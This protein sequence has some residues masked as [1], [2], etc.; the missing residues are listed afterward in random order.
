MD[1]KH[2]KVSKT[3]WMVSVSITELKWQVKTWEIPL[4][5]VACLT[6]SGTSLPSLSFTKD[7]CSN[8]TLPTSSIGSHSPGKKRM[9]SFQPQAETHYRLSQVAHQ[10]TLAYARDP[11]RPRL[12]DFF[13]C[14]PKRRFPVGILSLFYEK[15]DVK[16]DFKQWL[17]CFDV[18]QW[19]T[20]NFIVRNCAKRATL[21]YYFG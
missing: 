7:L 14:L 11:D 9:S 21:L 18:R 10:E 17:T 1:R 3:V 16:I 4:Q 5:E 8:V 15:N 6:I 19:N 12:W 13:L 20:L 2:P